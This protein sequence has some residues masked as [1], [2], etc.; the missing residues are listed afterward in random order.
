M[1]FPLRRSPP[2]KR[3]II[4][5]L[6]NF[7]PFWIIALIVL[8]VGCALLVNFFGAA[9]S[10]WINILLLAAAL[11]PEVLRRTPRLYLAWTRFKYYLLNRESIWSLNCEF[12]GVFKERDLESFLTSLIADKSVT[13][14]ILN[15]SPDEVMI[16]FDHRVHA[17]LSL[18]NSP[19]GHDADFQAR[20]Y[21][22][23][24]LAILDHQI[25]YRKSIE[26]MDRVILPLIERLEHAF[27]CLSRKYALRIHFDGTNPF[28]GLYAQQVNIDRVREFTFIFTLPRVRNDDYVRIEKNEMIIVARS[29][30][31]FRASTLAGLAF[32]LPR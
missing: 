17:R 30:S 31:D 25:S 28:F 10:T 5:I 7:M 32:H 19:S 9:A 23:L 3:K 18:S 15:R 21:S 6:R 16:T 22:S 29:Q 12:G 24:S 1:E 13:I 11:G 8:T 20:D 27:N 4:S 26:T 14:A 2:L